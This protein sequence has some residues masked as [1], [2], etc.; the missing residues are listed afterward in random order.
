MNKF[1][2]RRNKLINNPKKI[3]FASKLSLF[4][5]AAFL[6]LFITKLPGK[7]KI[8][9]ISC[10]TQVGPCSPETSLRLQNL[11]NIPFYKL[12]QKSIEQKAQPLKIISYKIKFPGKLEIEID[13]PKPAVILTLTTI[14]VQYLVSAQG[15][16]LGFSQGQALPEVISDLHTTPEIGNIIKDLATFQAT[17]L[18]AELSRLG[19]SHPKI[20]LS[21]DILEIKNI[22]D[23]Q[24]ITSISNDPTQT[25]AT[26][27]QLLTKAKIVDSQPSKI[28][29][30]F[31][32]PVILY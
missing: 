5:L 27:Q 17:I 13:S 2:T 20:Y 6:A 9:S 29:L 7:L 22:I 1:I 19:F 25:A 18:A 32:Q 24:I 23:T 16:I 12:N 14:Q 11:L 31:S 10:H 15:Q 8:N 21:G 26:L 28:D 4:L 30:R 3:R